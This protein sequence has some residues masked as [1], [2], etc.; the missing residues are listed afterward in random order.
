MSL[1]ANMC[2]GC[3]RL[4]GENDMVTI[5]SFFIGTI[6][7]KE[8]VNFFQFDAVS[9]EE[10]PLVCGGLLRRKTFSKRRSLAKR[11][12]NSQR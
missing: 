7:A 6:S 2:D 5:I 12:L 11:L 10:K 1:A 8:S 4:V 9:C 3:N